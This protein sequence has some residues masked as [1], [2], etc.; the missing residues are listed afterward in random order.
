MPLA[1][2]PTPRHNCSSRKEPYDG[3]GSVPDISM[4][5]DPP[6]EVDGNPTSGL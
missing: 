2:L 4:R 6:T 1:L 5:H 3:L